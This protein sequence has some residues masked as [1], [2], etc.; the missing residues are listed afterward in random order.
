MGVLRRIIASG[1]V[2]Q[3]ADISEVRQ[4]DEGF[5]GMSGVV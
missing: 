3:D 1:L 2:F 4:D 5:H